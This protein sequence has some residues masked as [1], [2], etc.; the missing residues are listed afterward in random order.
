MKPKGSNARKLIRASE[1]AWSPDGRRLAIRRDGR[2]HTVHADGTHLRRLTTHFH[3][4]TPVWSPDR[5]PVSEASPPKH[6]PPGEEP[7]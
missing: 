5:H 2:I 6:L 7:F 3:D 1:A 4:R